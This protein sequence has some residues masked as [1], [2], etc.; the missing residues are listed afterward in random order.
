[1]LLCVPFCLFPVG[2]TDLVDVL[3]VVHPAAAKW[4]EIGLTLRINPDELDKISGDADAGLRAVLALWLRG[5]GGDRTWEFLCEVLRH[6]LVGRRD[7][8]KKIQ[9]LCM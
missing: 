5:N 2:I 7:L 4:K 3:A 9:Y 6:P 1:M 8:A